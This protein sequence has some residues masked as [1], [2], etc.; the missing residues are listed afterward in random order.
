MRLSGAGGKVSDSGHGKTG[1]EAIFWFRI[2]GP[3]FL[4]GEKSAAASVRAWSSSNLGFKRL[5]SANLP[6][7]V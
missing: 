5:Q 4:P 3:A 1:V 2:D 6:G 7:F